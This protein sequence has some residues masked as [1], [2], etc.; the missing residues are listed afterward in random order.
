V[1]RKKLFRRVARLSG[2]RPVDR[3]LPSGQVQSPVSRP[4]NTRRPTLNASASVIPAPS[5]CW[6]PSHH[7]RRCSSDRKKFSLVQSTAHARPSS[8]FNR[9]TTP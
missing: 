2:R 6:L 7:A 3:Y 4:P 9:V 5:S 1:G 8:R